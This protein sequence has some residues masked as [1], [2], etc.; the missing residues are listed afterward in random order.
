LWNLLFLAG[1]LGGLLLQ[2]L[3]PAPWGEVAGGAIMLVMAGR[4]LWATPL[5]LRRGNS[6][7]W[8]PL[9]G[10]AIMFAGIFV[11]MVPALDLLAAHGRPAW[12]NEPWQYFWLTGG[13]S[14]LLDNAP[15]YLTFSTM[16]AESDHFAPLVENRVP[17]IDGPLMLKAI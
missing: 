1:V 3:L 9:V 5:R 12:L 10:A 7:P 8:G 6:F 4:S 11:T 2:R 14:S 15:T 16:A 17:G 13:L